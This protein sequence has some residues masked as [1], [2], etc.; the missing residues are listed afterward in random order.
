[1][2]SRV[3]PRPTRKGRSVS[4]QAA[5]KSERFP[6][7]DPDQRYG[8]IIDGHTVP[9]VTGNSFRLVDPYEDREWGYVPEASAADVDLAVAAARR[10][11]PLWAATPPVARGMVLRRWADL[12]REHLEEL[13]RT[14]VHENGKTVTEMRMAT[15]SVALL[16]DFAAQYANA[17]HGVTVTPGA[18]NHD[19]WTRKEPLGVVA[20]ITPWN[21]PLTLLSWK[22]IPAVAAGNTVVIKPSEV[23]PVSTLRLVELAHEAG[24]PAGVINVVTG[25]GE[26]GAALVEHPDI[27]KIAFTGSTATGARIAQT[28][29]KR[30]LRTTLELGGKGP[31]IVFP[32]A[33]LDRAV[34]S[35][36]AGV[37]SGTGQAC[38]AGSRILIHGSIYDEVVAKLA[39]ALATVKIGDPLDPE[40]AIGPLASRA[41]FSK[42]TGYLTIAEGEGATELVCGGRSGTEVP[43]VAQGLFVEPTLFA[44]PDPE[45]RIRVEEIFGPVGAIIRFNDEADAVRIANESEFGLVA[46]LWTQDVDRASRV[47]KQLRAGVVWIN[48]WRAFSHNMPFGGVKASGVGRELGLDMFDEYTETKS[49]WLG[50]AP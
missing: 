10:A 8:L 43:G 41:Q 27:D 20:A 4:T 39:A 11:F 40:V 2:G 38:N 3:T 42:V 19:A 34:Q 28:A 21:N 15:A 25:G 30:F 6:E 47:S 12:I 50:L 16:A 5:T 26:A 33:D 22:L 44:T 1:M 32:E 24:L 7:F 23:T 35:L 36:V 29:A 37:I 14:Q 31:Q 9:A 46:G 45:S 17:I 48:T 13:A 49:V 18:P